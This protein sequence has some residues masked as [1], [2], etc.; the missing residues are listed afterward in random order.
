[1]SN[2]SRNIGDIMTTKK[3]KTV[4]ERLKELRRKKR[5]SQEKLANEMNITQKAIS[6]FE[7]NTTPLSMEYIIKFSEYFNVSC[8]YLIKGLDS[9]SMLKELCNNISLFYVTTKIG[10]NSFEIPTLSIRSNLFNYL[11]V[12]AKIENDK[13]MPNDIKNAWLEREIENYY[14]SFKSN[15]NTFMKFI[16]LPEQMIYPDDNKS[17]WKQSDLIRELNVKLMK[18]IKH[19]D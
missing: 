1:M 6:N 10:E 16:P 9:R 13:I 14:S 4:G 18:V 17:D 12:S 5:L 11:M 7:T 8:D 19:E 15:E 3:E 2:K